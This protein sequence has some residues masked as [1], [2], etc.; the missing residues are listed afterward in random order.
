MYAP[1]PRWL[2]SFLAFNRT[3][4]PPAAATQFYGR[5]TA[6]NEIDLAGPPT[7]L[8]PIIHSILL[9]CINDTIGMSI[10]FVEASKTNIT[11]FF[12]V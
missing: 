5:T 12:V 10:P 1:R 8:S 3:C 4:T 7:P 2:A 11:V 6:L 9:S